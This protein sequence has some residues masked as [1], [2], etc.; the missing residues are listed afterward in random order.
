MS[1]ND[2]IVHCFAGADKIFRGGDIVKLDFV[3]EKNGWLADACVTAAI[4]ATGGHKMRTAA[5]GW[6]T[7]TADGGRCAHFEWTVAITESGPENLTPWHLAA[8]R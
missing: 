6:N 5:D 7:Y 3:A 8:A 4:V 1:V 2:E